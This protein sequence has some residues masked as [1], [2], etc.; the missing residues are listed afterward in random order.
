MARQQCYSPPQKTNSQSKIETGVFATLPGRGYRQSG[1]TDGPPGPAKG[2]SR[3]RAQTRDLR[4]Q[5]EPFARALGFGFFSYL[6]LR[7]SG[8][9]PTGYSRH[10]Y[11]SNLPD[12]LNAR[13]EHE[14]LHQQDPIVAIGRLKCEIFTWHAK[15][16]DLC[17]TDA[18]HRVV[19]AMSACRIS[20]GI[21]VPIHGPRGELSLLTFASS[22]SRRDLDETA[23]VLGP[24]IH[25]VA[26][27]NHA[28]SFAET[29][30]DFE[31]LDRS[32]T[33]REKE[34]L[35]WTAQGKTSWEISKIIGRT[36][37]T[38]NFHLKNAVS[39]LDATNKCHA[40]TK[41]IARGLVY[42]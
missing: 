31:P 20:C 16:P 12:A 15:D 5:L 13:Y 24:S 3:P 2:G 35:F 36:E 41:A 32:L 17:L 19:G 30:E 25:W 28:L 34:C 40:V 23:A 10:G 7:G 11:V 39:K 37:A 18:H 22:D 1:V 9:D 14:N 29:D 33:A 21:T 42:F 26:L 38:V 27:S 4:A 8:Q 6:A